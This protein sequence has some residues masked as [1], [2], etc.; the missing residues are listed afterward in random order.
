[1]NVLILAA[2]LTGPMTSLDG[3]WLSDG[4]GL[5]FSI[6]GDTLESWEVTGVSCLPSMAARSVPAPP[7]S[8]SAFR[9]IDRPVTLLLLPDPDASR[10]RVHVNGTA[11]D[12]V[13]QRVAEKPSVCRA[14]LQ[15]VPGSTSTSSRRPGPSTIH[16]FR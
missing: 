11:S 6:Q 16:S 1:M 15:K 2:A 5:V 14:T 7:G 3:I 10:M 4:Y 12:M 8:L 13:V 9:L